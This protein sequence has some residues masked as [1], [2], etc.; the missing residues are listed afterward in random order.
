MLRRFSFISIE[1]ESME[2]I[3]HRKNKIEQA[4]L[5]IDKQC[6]DYFILF[7]YFKWICSYIYLRNIY[8]KTF[9]VKNLFYYQNKKVYSFFK[10]TE[11]KIKDHLII[12]HGSEIP[13]EYL[14]SFNGDEECLCL[15]FFATTKVYSKKLQ[16]EPCD[17]IIFI[18]LCF[19]SKEIC[20][21]VKLLIT[22]CMYYHIKYNKINENVLDYYIKFEKR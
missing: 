22:R 2:L 10:L 12:I 15:R 5:F 17:N 11:L 1:V 3:E 20:T 19:E 21:Q 8:T 9:K 14:I 7:F 4:K 16:I 13:Y 6:T 18:M